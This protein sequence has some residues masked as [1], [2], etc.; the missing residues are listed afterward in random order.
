VPR[1]IHLNG[2]PGI[3]KSTL[4]KRYGDE[5]PGTLVLD[6]DELRAM[7]GGWR[8]DFRGA[9]AAIRTA[10][11]A[12]VTAYLRSG[13]D[14]VVPQLVARP[15]Q[16]DRFR[17]AATEAAAGYV[18]VLLMAPEPDDVVRRFRA[19]SVVAGD[20]PWL[21]RVEGVVAEQ[22]GDAALL[23]DHQILAAL[24]AE[25]PTIV[26]VPSTDPDATYAAMLL[27]LERNA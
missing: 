26:T 12:M 11:L 9:G 4:A 5:H 24:A 1:L 8:D 2:P 13:G 7:V 16:L 10:A 14:V 3:G 17:G 19:R 23:R 22:G 25:D 27:A 21:T 18:C 15:D 6:I 20:D